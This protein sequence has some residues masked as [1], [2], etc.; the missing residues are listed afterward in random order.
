MYAK[1]RSPECI[2]LHIIGYHKCMADGEKRQLV[3]ILYLKKKRDTKPI[4]RL[5]VFLGVIN[6]SRKSCCTHNNIS[7]IVLHELR[8][9]IN[10]FG[11][12]KDRNDVDN[13]DEHDGEDYGDDDDDEHDGDDDDDN[14]NNNNNRMSSHLFKTTALN[15]LK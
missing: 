3:Y 5:S 15:H 4:N 12:H 10:V 11:V 6:R 8:A 9:V 14:N 13:D 7:H 1:D 2:L